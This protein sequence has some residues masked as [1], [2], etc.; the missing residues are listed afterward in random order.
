MV[1]EQAK[2]AQLSLLPAS[3]QLLFNPEDGGSKFLQNV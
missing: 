3:C 1:E 2:Q